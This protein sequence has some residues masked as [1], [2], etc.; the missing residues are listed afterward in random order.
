MDW[1]I[2]PF[3]RYADFSGRSQRMEYWMFTL[4]FIIVISVTLLLAGGLDAMAGDEGLFGSVFGILLVIF[5]LA[6]VIPSI[7]VT[8]RRLHDQDKSGWWYLISFIPYLGSLVLL[9]FMCLDGT[10]GSNKYGPDPK[11]RGNADIFS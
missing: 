1:M 10:P 7:A 4:L 2:M 9:V 3:K 6:S 5:F 8:V 11:D